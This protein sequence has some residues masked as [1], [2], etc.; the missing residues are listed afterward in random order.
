MPRELEAA[1]QIDGCTRWG[2]FWRVVLPLV[3][4]GLITVGVF[5]FLFTW[6]QFLFALSLNTNESVQPV[7]WRSTNSLVSTAPSGTC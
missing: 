5:A 2:A 4:P 7:R 1:A 6:G 3:Q